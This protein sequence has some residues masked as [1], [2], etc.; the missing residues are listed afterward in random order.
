MTLLVGLENFFLP[1]KIIFI[2]SLIC[3]QTILLSPQWSKD[4]KY[5]LRFEIRQWEG[6][7]KIGRTSERDRQTNT[8]TNTALYYIDMLVKFANSTFS[9]K[10]H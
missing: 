3:L 8:Q 10:F 7:E 5:V 2:S 4:S 9:Y 6:G 1:A